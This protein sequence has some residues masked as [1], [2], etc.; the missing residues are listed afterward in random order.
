MHE[1]STD[2]VQTRTKTALL[3]CAFNP[4]ER[5]LELLSALDTEKFTKILVIDDGS[6]AV[7]STIFKKAQTIQNLEVK[8]F[9][10]NQGKG[11]ALQ[12]GLRS[13]TQDANIEWIVTADCDGQHHPSDIHA[14]TESAIQ[15]ESVEY[16]LGARDFSRSIPLRNWLGNQFMRALIRLILGRHIRDSQTGLR[17]IH[18][19]LVPGLYNSSLTSFSYETWQLLTVLRRRHQILEVPITTIYNQSIPSHFRPIRDSFSIVRTL[20]ANVTAFYR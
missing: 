17:A 2:H 19:S 16:I 5:F 3:V 8:Q 9:A 10:E 12:F 15:G 1:P 18:R 7:S 13:L 11:A 20:F 6:N 14:V 4:D